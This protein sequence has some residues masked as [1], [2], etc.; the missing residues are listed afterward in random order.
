M[1][2]P[3]PSASADTDPD[4]DASSD[5][6]VFSG[7]GVASAALGVLSVAALALGLLLW[8]VHRDNVGERDHQTRVLAAAVEWTGVLINMNIDTVDA[9]LRRLHEGTV[10]QLNVEFVSAMQSY[11][12]VVQK[13]KPHSVGQVESVAIESV[14]H[15]PDARPAARPRDDPLPEVASRVDTVLLVATSV[16][17]N[18]SGKP[19]TVHWNLR[20]DVADVDGKLLISRLGSIR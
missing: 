20:L 11:R 18:V 16:A 19:Q 7:Y 9:D 4:D 6:R 8:S 12:Q 10:G 3:E 15:D 5:G 13:L 1:S 14:H 2:D 17:E